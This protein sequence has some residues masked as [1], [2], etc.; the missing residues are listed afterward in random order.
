MKK[1]RF[2]LGILIGILLIVASTVIFFFVQKEKQVY[3]KDDAPDSVVHNY[4]LAIFN[5]DYEMA[6]DFLQEEEYKPTYFEF[7][8]YFEDSGNGYGG[9]GYDSGL[10]N[11][12]L[13]VAETDVF[14]KRATVTIHT[15][16][17]SYGSFSNYA[18]PN[19]A[20][21]VSQ[22]GEWKLSEVDVYELWSYDW[23]QEPY[24][25]YRE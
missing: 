9:Y 8:T 14:G 23:Y 24:D 17:N 19:K 21:L 1:D 20:K 4:A 15:L 13:E 11:T 5:E 18:Y 2:L 16:N 22:E 3:K 6:Y 25:E 7:L 12:A 10:D